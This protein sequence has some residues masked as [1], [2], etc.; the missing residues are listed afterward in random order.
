[1]ARRCGVIFAVVS[2]LATLPS[3]AQNFFTERSRFLEQLQPGFYEEQFEDWTIGEPL[4]GHQTEWESPDQNGWSWTVSASGSGN[5]FLYSLYQAVSTSAHT[6]D[7]VFQFT[8]AATFVFAG[9]FWGTQYDGFPQ[10]TDLEIE[11]D[12]GLLIN[13]E[14]SGPTFIGIVSDVPINAVTV[15]AIGPVAAWPTA[16]RVTVGALAQQGDLDGDGMLNA[17]EQ[18]A[19]TSVTDPKSN[20][21]VEN[22]A[23]N[24][25]AIVVRFLAVAN[26]VYRLE[27]KNDL[28]DST[29]LGAGAAD[30]APPT[31]GPSEFIESPDGCRTLRFYRVGVIP[32]I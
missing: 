32:P 5:Q 10:T 25:E 30:Q 26:K 11:T 23:V 14:V 12:S 7:L 21:R 28:V 2:L 17:A 4:D 16:A 9:E 1:M 8:G 6:D 27:Y 13:Q 29:W 24:D 31:T 20:L 3:L 15:R 22:M 19:G 18:A